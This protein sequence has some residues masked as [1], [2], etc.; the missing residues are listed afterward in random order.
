MNR[1]ARLGIVL[2]AVFIVP[3]AAAGAVNAQAMPL[4]ARAQLYNGDGIE[5]GQVLFEQTGTGVRTVVEVNNLPKGVYAVHIHENGMCEAPDFKS[6]G[7]HFNPEGKKPGL[8]SKEG[9]YA[10]DLPHIRVDD[11]GQGRMAVVTDRVTLRKGEPD[12]LFKPGGTAVVIQQG[13]GNY[14]TDLAVEGARIA[15]G[16]IEEVQ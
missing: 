11:D 12:S 3:F 13:G 8:M 7:G 2:F 16:V 5:I 10:G 15:C 4:R 14:R 6:A 9:P 1:V